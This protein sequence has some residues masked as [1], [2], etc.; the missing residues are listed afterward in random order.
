[1]YIGDT[2]ILTNKAFRATLGV[3]SQMR[4]QHASAYL[5]LHIIS[6]DTNTS[7]EEYDR[8]I[9]RAIRGTDIVGQLDN[10]K[11]YT[12]LPQAGLE[13]MPQIEKRFMASG[14]SCTVVTQGVDYA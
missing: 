9:G 4:K 2:H 1:M 11:I 13:N 7:I 8:R 6:A 14:L 5:L 10:G 12:L 3:Y